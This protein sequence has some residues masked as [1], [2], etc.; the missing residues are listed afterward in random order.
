MPWRLR[1]GFC[2]DDAVLAA[3]DPVDPGQLHQPL[4]LV[5]AQLEIGAA[6]GLPQLPAPVQPTVAPP[7]VVQLVGRVPVIQLS[8]RGPEATGGV[9]VSHVD[10]AI[11]MPCWF[12]TARIGS[13]P[14]R[15]AWT[16]M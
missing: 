6:G 5:P 13:T 7:Q 11:P 1:V 9:G 3:A 16:R 2:G 10:G 4:D 14:N 8:G 12:S 15:S